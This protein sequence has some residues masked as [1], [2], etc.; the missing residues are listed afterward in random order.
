MNTPGSHE[1]YAVTAD[2]YDYVV[3]YRT[4]ADIDF[5]VEA[6][7]AS[8]GPVLEV[9]R[10]TG[11]VLIPTARGGTDIVGLDLSPHM[12]QVCRERLKN[13]PEA[14]RSK[15]RLLSSSAGLGTRGCSAANR[16]SSGEEPL[17]ERRSPDS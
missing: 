10:G 12:L 7:R 16:T 15:T 5:F 1:E 9:G 17:H 8:G 11:R 3:P 13:E 14:V 2:L 4:R 6:A